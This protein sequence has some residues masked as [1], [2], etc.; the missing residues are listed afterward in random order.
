VVEEDPPGGG[1]FDAAYAADHELSAD[2][3]LQILHLAA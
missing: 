1:E 2:L 3:V